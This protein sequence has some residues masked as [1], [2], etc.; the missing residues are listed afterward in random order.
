[1]NSRAATTS[2]K[3]GACMPTSYQFA[4]PEDKMVSDI[5]IDIADQLGSLTRFIGHRSSHRFEDAYCHLHIKKI[6]GF[7]IGLDR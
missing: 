3:V 4:E 5:N 1:M 7:G 6:G 2:S